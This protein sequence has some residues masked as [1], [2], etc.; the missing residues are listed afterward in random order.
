MNHQPSTSDWAAIFDWDGVIVDSSAQHEASWN[1]LAQRE[2]RVLPAGHFKKGFGMKNEV[3][4]PEVLGWA[5]EPAEIDRLARAKE[6]IYRDLVDR[7]G[8]SPIPGVTEWLT[9]L[10][11]SGVPCAIGSSTHRLNI[12]CVLRHIHL[13]DFFAAIVAGNDVT[14]GKPAPDIFLKA[15]ERLGYL[16][17]RCVVFEDA[18]VGI[19]AARAGGMKVVAVTTTHPAESLQDADVVVGRLDELTVGRMDEWMNG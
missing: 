13:A 2:G 15:A 9:T 4:I 12:D 16:P 14:H 5:K 8:I 7:D 19:E 10:K 3:I 6:Q 18:H 11:A 17:T 1:V